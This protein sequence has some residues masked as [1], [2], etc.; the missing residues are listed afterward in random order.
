[1]SPSSKGAQ[2]RSF[3]LQAEVLSAEPDGSRQGDLETSP[4]EKPSGADSLIFSRN[5]VGLASYTGLESLTPLS[6][7]WRQI[8][9]STEKTT[10]RLLTVSLLLVLFTISINSLSAATEVYFA[11]ALRGS[12]DSGTS[13][14]LI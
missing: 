12:A 11:Q 8:L 4:T 14:I 10:R 13:C 1:M 5:N 7:D 2:I 3:G 6:T 9:M